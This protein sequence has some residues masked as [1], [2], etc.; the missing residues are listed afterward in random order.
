MVIS[1]LKF[2]KDSFLNIF[3][4]NSIIDTPFIPSTKLKKP[5]RP[6]NKIKCKDDTICM[7]MKKRRAV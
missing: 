4:D 1:F 5:R 7:R 6:M 3:P 2:I